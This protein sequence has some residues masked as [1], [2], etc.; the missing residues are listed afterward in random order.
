LSPELARLQPFAPIFSAAV[1]GEGILAA[2]PLDEFATNLPL[3]GLR[4]VS[5]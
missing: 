5:P 3:T 2:V 1:S 4:T